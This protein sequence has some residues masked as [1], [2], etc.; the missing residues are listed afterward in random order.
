MAESFSCS[1][2]LILIFF[3]YNLWLLREKD[4]H[5]GIHKEKMPSLLSSFRHLLH[6]CI[7]LEILL[8]LPFLN[9][10]FK[11]FHLSACTQIPDSD[12]SSLVLQCEYLLTKSHLQNIM[13]KLFIPIAMNYINIK[14]CV[15]TEMSK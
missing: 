8:F 2:I 13:L 15:A 6:A 10:L 9:T 5:I 3:A 14:S 12:S 4:L 1:Q 7:M 11:V